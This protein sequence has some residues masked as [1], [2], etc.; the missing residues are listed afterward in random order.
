VSRRI[1]GG[2]DDAGFVFKGDNNESIDP[3]K[4]KADKLIGGVV[5]HVPRPGYC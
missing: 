1:T 5:P 2:D 4:P 3:L